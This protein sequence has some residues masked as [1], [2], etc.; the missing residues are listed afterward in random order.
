MVK[1]ANCAQIREQ[2]LDATSDSLAGGIRTAFDTHLSGC[3]ECA[4]EFRRVQTLAQAMDRSLRASLSV[5][6]PPQ[7]ISNVRREIIAPPHRKTWWGERS[8]WL[9]AAG[10]C[11]VLAILVLAVRSSHELNSPA[12]NHSTASI[13]VPS[14]PKPA[15]RPPVNAAMQA[16]TATQPRKP[17]VAIVSHVSQRVSHQRS[18]EPEIIVDPG[19]M[20]AILRFAAAAESGQIDGA[21]LLIDQKKSAEPLEIKPLTIS[22]LKI[23]ALDDDAAS[24]RASSDSEN[25]DKNFVVARQSD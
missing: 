5:E 2:M 10:V 11:A 1:A 7:L 18:T 14:T 3:A 21:K 12:Q 22:P 20:Q 15:V 6:P 19:Q 24:P 16:A 23:V 17:A 8:A 4:E 13:N 9:T 25:G